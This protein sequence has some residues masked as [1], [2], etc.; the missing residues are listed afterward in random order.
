MTNKIKSPRE[1]L[2][3]YTNKRSL[4]SFHI[5]DNKILNQA[6]KDLDTYYKKEYEKKIMERVPSIE[7]MTSII[8]ATSYNDK[9]AKAIHSLIKSKLKG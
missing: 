6:L 4:S 1:I 7:E 9:A 2:K 8:Y 3:E 5:H